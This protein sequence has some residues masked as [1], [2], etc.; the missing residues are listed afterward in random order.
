MTQ[1]IVLID[2]NSLAY[3]AFFALPLLN[4]D[5]GIHTN[6]IYGFTMILM[7]I[8]QEEKPTHMLVA[9]DAGKTTF[10][11]STF[12][13]YK[14]GRQKTPPELSEQMP[15]LRELLDAFQ[16]KRYELPNYEADDIIGTL[17]K[18]AEG[19]DTEI[20]V[21]TGDKDLLQLVSEHT[22]VD[23]TRKGITEVDSYTPEFLNE[24]LGITPN[25]IV[26]MKGLMGDAS[27]NI[28]GVPGVGEKTAIKLLKEYETVENLYEHI[29]GVSGKLKEKLEENKEQALM[30]KKLAT[31][32]RDAP[33]TVSVEDLTYENFN[34]DAV[35][36]LFKELN[37]HSLLE[38]MDIQVTEPKKELTKLQFEIVEELNDDVLSDHSSL[39]VETF[40]DHYHHAD[41]LG[42]AISNETGHYYIPTNVALQ[43]S[44]FKQWAK[45][46]NKRKALYDGKQAIVALHGQGIE[47]KGI[48]FDLMIADYICNPSDPSEDLAAIA[49]KRGYHDVQSDELVYGK[50]A[51]KSIPAVQELSEHLVRKAV[52]IHSLRETFE[53]ELESN[54][55]LELYRELE[56]PLSFILAEMEYTGVKVDKSR[57]EDMQQELSIRLAELEREIHLLAGEA[58]NINS[59]KQLGV[60]LFEKLGLPPVKKTK[61]GYSTSAD[62]LE[63][64]EGKHEVIR[65][66][67]TYRQL[68]KL[69]STYLEGL[70]KVINGK[71]G[72]VHT[73][74]NQTLA[75][76]GRLSSI[77]PNLQN[78]PIRLEEGRKI[79]QA[80]VP[81]NKD[82]VIFAADYSQIELRVLAHIAGDEKLIHA[83][84][85]DFDI[86]TQTAMDV[87]GVEANVVTSDMRRQAKAVNFGIVYGISDYGL[88]QSLGITRKD[89]SIF[90]DKYLKS[91]PGVQDYMSD[92][93]IEAKEKGYVSTLMQRR[94]Y[95]PDITHRNFNLRSFAER[96]AMNTPIQG[97]AADI[98]KKAMIDLADALR[99]EKFEAKLLLQVHDELILE[100]PKHEIEKLTELVP[101]V[102][103]NTLE[104][105]VPLK[106]DYA[107][108]PTWY[109]AK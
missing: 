102:M 57:L 78:I 45:D 24:K 1:K 2:G 65:A 8:L 80:F 30:S 75:Q 74:F 83:F 85:N 19:K 10:R 103:E 12:K 16:V 62:V 84:N 15:F 48:D 13:E 88:S 67:L 59:P 36:K 76:T 51:K 20:K 105:K 22:T 41:V 11:H 27:D 47:L 108:G 55:Q 21:I 72:R 60:M 23:I 39:S 94:R 32:M 6:A 34:K 101:R 93:I 98:I 29:T 95:I 69:N 89:A 61:T 7:R 17:S 73:R 100:A 97:S 64:L 26:D 52:A 25:Q 37:F 107:Y 96:T 33:I 46:E 53:Q 58:F 99:D 92:I 86:H 40:S 91:F 82:W 35:I 50:G 28:P 43:S 104:L 109:D 90:I 71:T 63:K 38:K 77:E 87:F 66:I 68:G 31:I 44:Q 5:K 56:L 49:Q 79:R 9:F 81:T 14:G 42:L 3:R 106:V 54:D 4:N 18:L 70:L